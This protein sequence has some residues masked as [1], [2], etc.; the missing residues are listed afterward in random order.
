MIHAEPKAVYGYFEETDLNYILERCKFMSYFD[1]TAYEIGDINTERNKGELQ[2]KY[3][4]YA[5]SKIEEM[6][7]NGTWHV[8]NHTFPAFYVT[9][10]KIWMLCPLITAISK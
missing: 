2:Y 10:T 7:P 8:P 5:V 3:D 4:P 6:D 1:G 9:D